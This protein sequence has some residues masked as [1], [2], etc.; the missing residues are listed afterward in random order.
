MEQEAELLELLHDS[1]GSDPVVL[2]ASAERSTKR[3]G[4]GKNVRAEGELLAKLRKRFGADNV[5]VVEK[6]IEKLRRM[7]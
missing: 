7:H 5:K 1:D 2:Y 3:L 4:A 6:R